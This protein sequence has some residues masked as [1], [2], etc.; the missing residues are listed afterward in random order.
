MAL[1]RKVRQ[2]GNSLAL[3][4][5]NEVFEFLGFNSKDIKYKLIQEISGQVFI[6]ILKK[7]VI[8]LDEKK[9]QKLGRTPA[10]IIPKPLCILWNI[11]LEEDKNRELYIEF[12]D[13]PLKWRLYP[14]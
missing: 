12:D 4:V 11:G 2:I 13:S 3:P 14:V 8:S 6:L 10:I 9:F 7:D 5:P 1:K